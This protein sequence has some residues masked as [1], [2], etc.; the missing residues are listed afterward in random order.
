MIQIFRE[1]HIVFTKEEKRLT[2]TR[3]VSKMLEIVLRF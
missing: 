3:E 1:N 2:G